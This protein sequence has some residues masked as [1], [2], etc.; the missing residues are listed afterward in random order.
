MK[1]KLPSSFIYFFSKLN[2]LIYIC[3]F[4]RGECP[5][6]KGFIDPCVFDSVMQ[7]LTVEYKLTVKIKNNNN[8]NNNN[9]DD[10]K[11]NY[12]ILFTINFT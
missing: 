6:A 3:I 1:I 2:C 7:A 4:A 9:N 12:K 11:A 10:N 5:I 8:N